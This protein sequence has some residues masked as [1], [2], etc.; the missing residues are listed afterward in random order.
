[1]RPRNGK[2]RKSA[3]L[4]QRASNNRDTRSNKFTLK[5]FGVS[6][7]Y[8]IGS[9][10]VTRCAATFL[11]PRSRLFPCNAW[12]RQPQRSTARPA[13]ATSL[14]AAFNGSCKHATVR[15]P[16]TL[17][18]QEA[19]KEIPFWTRFTL[20]LLARSCVFE[21][22]PDSALCASPSQLPTALTFFC[23]SKFLTRVRVPAK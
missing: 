4:V 22:L 1:M 9:G 14:V 2:N 10:H 19:T 18:Q 12:E 23:I 6:L 8:V 13:L 3:G 16:R 17:M 5:S 7:F 21:A 15:M 20:L 11:P